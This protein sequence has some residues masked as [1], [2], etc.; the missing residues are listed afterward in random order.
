VR[1]S[2]DEVVPDGDA[3]VR[4][5]ERHDGVGKEAMQR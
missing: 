4:R 1:P 2:V 3:R 5:N